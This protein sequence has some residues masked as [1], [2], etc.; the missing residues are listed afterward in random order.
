M[1]AD[2]VRRLTA[3][4]PTSLLLTKDTPRAMANI[5][6]DQT[7]ATSSQLNSLKMKSANFNG[8]TRIYAINKNDG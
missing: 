8:A 1:A 7:L 4:N 2:E 3:L 5:S 6:L